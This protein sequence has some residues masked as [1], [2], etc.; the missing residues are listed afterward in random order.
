MHTDLLGNPIGGY[1]A[2][3][4]NIHQKRQ[5]TLLYHWM[6]LDYLKGLK[7]MID[8]LIK[9]V[10]VNLALAKQQGR[11]E[12][13][14][15]PRWGI[16]DT[17]INWSTNVY[18][19]LEDFRQATVRD[20]AQRANERY[21]F[22]GANQCAR[23]IQEFSSMW[24]TPEEE[25]TFK[26]EFQEVY[27]Y[28]SKIDDAAGSGGRRHQL[29]DFNMYLEWTENEHLFPKLPKFKVRTDITGETGKRPPRTG[30]YVAQ[31]DELATLQ[32]AWR[33]YD[34]G[35]LG[36]AETLSDLGREA[37][38][39][40]GRDSMWQNHARMKQWVLEAYR[41]GEKLDFGPLGPRENFEPERAGRIISR[42]TKHSRAC[43]WY[44]V[45]MIGG[46]F[47]EEDPTAPASA[48]PRNTG[49][50]RCEAGQPCP[51]SGYWFTPARANSRSCF[52]RGQVMPSTGGD[53]GATIWQWDA[54]QGEAPPV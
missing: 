10:D 21:E 14:A 36:D 15:N 11:D 17:A 40:I 2:M 24:M 1:P 22:T 45:E 38:K 47:D 5:A 23:M 8:A 9:G 25:E 42:S 35:E 18:P 31:D 30:V 51:Q 54:N 3:N 34:N 20:I 44:F 16:R 28:A 7:A 27:R 13:I 49:G 39:V 12:L 26:K 48:A 43:K 29:N 52:E 37:V 6:S 33:G 53:Y 41:R 46:E 4:L 32:F 19:A 50:L